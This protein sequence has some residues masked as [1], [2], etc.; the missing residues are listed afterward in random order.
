[1]QLRSI[2]IL[3]SVFLSI[4]FLSGYCQP[5]WNS[6]VEKQH[7]SDW[8]V[9]SPKQKAD[10]Y[11]SPNRKDII[12]FN[13]LLKRGFRIS[14]NVACIDYKNL[15]NGQ[16]LL[17]AVKPE[18]R[19]TIDGKECQVGGLYGQTENAY[20]LHEWIDG[21]TKNEGDFQFMSYKIS[22]IE[23]YVKWKYHGWA[24]NRKQPT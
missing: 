4:S 18:A 1:M 19:L 21:L 16:Q 20:L 2:Q 7:E 3:F 9:H 15:S 6:S 23:P 8:L 11:I 24:M 14:P 22:S 5:T 12:L 17:R 13:G 10:V